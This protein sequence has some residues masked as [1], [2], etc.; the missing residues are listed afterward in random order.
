MNRDKR[1]ARLVGGLIL[2]AYA[3]LGANNPDAKLMGMMLEVISGCAVI[4][5]AV[6][7]F[8]YLK[9]YGKKSSLAYYSLKGL[10]GILMI[11]AGLLFLIHTREFLAI[12]DKI[13]LFHGYVFAAAA[14]VFY[15]L[16][17]ISKLLPVW[18]SVWGMGAT[19]LLIIVNLLETAGIASGT[20]ILYLPIILNEVVLA[21]WLMAKGFNA[22]A[23][24]RE[25]ERGP[26]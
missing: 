22:H 1:T 18:L 6:L 23:I 9:P 4:A 11:V 16:L 3:I 12:R 8:P 24:K 19:I 21:I 20:Q 7:M 2:V 25:G 10:E 26:F 14:L 13:Y 5:T 17:L 15:G